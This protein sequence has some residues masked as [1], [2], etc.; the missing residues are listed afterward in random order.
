[1]EHRKL[2]S[3]N[4]S[5][6]YWIEGQGDQYIVFTHG[7]TMDHGL[8]QYQIEYFSQQYRVIVWDVPRHGLSRPYKGFSLPVA[9]DELIKILNSEKVK[10]AHFVGQSMGGYIIQFVARDHPERVMSLTAV[11]SSPLQP[12]Y[13]SK[14]DIWLLSI[15]PP[16]LRLFPYS[17]LI[18]TIAKQVAIKASSRSYAL[19]TLKNLTKNEIAGIMGT[20]YQGVKENK[21]DSALP[22]DL[23]IILG[24]ADRTGRVKTY[25]RRWAQREN[26]P[27]KIITNAAHNTNMDNPEQFNQILGDFLKHNK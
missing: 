26:R 14:L 23:L 1:M 17:K 7:A 19:K 16:L 13:Y 25:C 5:V 9:A 24:D 22:V 8:F 12:S 3:K 21:Y 11:G 27:L 15:T 4:G 20:V 2:Y 10:K 18:N 6:H